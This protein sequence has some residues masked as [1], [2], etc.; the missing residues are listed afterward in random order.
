MSQKMDRRDFIIKSCATCLSATVLGGFL[1][2]CSLTKYVSGD[3]NENG[4]VIDPKEFRQNEGKGESY[5]SFIIVRNETLQYPI[6]LYRFGENE[7]SAV[8]MQCTHQGTELQT[9]GELLHCPAH[10]SE[11]NNRGR[12]LHGPASTD[13]RNFPVTVSNDGIFIDLRKQ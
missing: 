6:Y 1:S 8:W 5:R 12:L 11:F 3:L 7:Y 4:V 2:S 13:L 9:S 10:G